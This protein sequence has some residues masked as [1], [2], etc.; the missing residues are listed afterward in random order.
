[1]GGG[2]HV[3][4]RAELIPAGAEQRRHLPSTS[5]GFGGVAPVFQGIPITR[6]ATAPISSTVE[7]TANP[8]RY[9]RRLARHRAPVP[10]TASRARMHAKLL[11]IGSFPSIS[12]LGRCLIP[13]AV[14][15]DTGI[16]Q[17]RRSRNPQSAAAITNFLPGTRRLNRKGPFPE[18]GM[19]RRFC[20]K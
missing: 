4:H 2:L 20:R 19:S 6:L 13:M 3:A 5:H 1:M 10:G 16:R 12:P 15:G 14:N 7:P 9:S 11:S 8:T 18:R 17:D